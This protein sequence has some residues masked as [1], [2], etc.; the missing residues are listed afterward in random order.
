MQ[1]PGR[2]SPGR[3]V[4]VVAVLVFLAAS[5]AQCTWLLPDTS[6]IDGQL[7]ETLNVDRFFGLWLVFNEEALSLSGKRS[8]H[9]RYGRKWRKGKVSAEAVLQDSG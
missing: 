1:G 5:P 4:V 3:A 2:P 9:F 7:T 8:T 6:G